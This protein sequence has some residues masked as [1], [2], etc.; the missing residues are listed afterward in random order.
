MT[1]ERALLL[2]AAAAGLVVAAG[3]SKHQTEMIL[4]IMTEGVRV[5]EDVHK[6]H[7][8]VADRQ[9]SLDDTVY[10]ADVEL[11]NPMLT[12]G[13]YDLPVTAVL[14]PGKS[15]GGDSVRVQVDAIGGGGTVIANAALFTFADEQ[16]LRL[17]FVLYANCL[18]NVECA[19]RDQACGPL[20]TCIDLKPGQTNGPLDLAQPRGPVDMTIPPPPDMTMVDLAG[21]DLTTV[22]A[23]L[24][25]TLD[26]AGCSGVVC[27][28]GEQCVAGQCQPCGGLGDPCCFGPTAPPPNWPNAGG[29][30]GTGSCNQT[31]LMC[32]GSICV[33]CG[34]D[35]QL[36]CPMVSACIFPDNCVGNIC[37]MPPDDMSM[38]PI[39]MSMMPGDMMMMGGIDLL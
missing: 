22:P 37:Q 26:L 14:F 25:T 1:K 15:R 38:M 33:Q 21:A 8:T 9:M 34:G 27:D 6:V 19:K 31:N 29:A 7:L 11:C 20:D 30:G 4:V 39:D 23:D 2:A 12:T 13:C 36:C 28:M 18:G 35:G 16:S 10:D 5:P 3:C 24:T 17:D 32:N